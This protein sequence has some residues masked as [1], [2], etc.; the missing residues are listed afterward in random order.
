MQ[1]KN[2]H[3]GYTSSLFHIGE[4]EL[5]TGQLYALIGANGKGK[6]TLLKTAVGEISPLSGKVLVNDQTIESYSNQAKSKII[7]LV[8]SRFAGI[9]YMK[10]EEYVALG[11]IPHTNAFG[12]LTKHDNDIINACFDYLSI[13]HLRDKFTLELS[14]GEKQMLAIAKVLAQE[15]PYILLD[16][17]TAFLDYKN[18][19]AVL[20]LLKEIAR[21]QNKCIVLSSHDLELTIKNVDTL[22]CIPSKKNELEV[23]SASSARLD[24]IVANCFN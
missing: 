20:N 18:K 3:I 11:R 23:L 1:I 9:S 16:E 8:N 15:T 10:A 13:Q 2:T 19:Q 6:S 7:G 12:R 14:D 4:L 22:L 21:T 24:E 5:K 17:P